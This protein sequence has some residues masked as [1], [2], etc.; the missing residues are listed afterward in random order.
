MWARIRVGANH[1]N[2]SSCEKMNEFHGTAVGK[3]APPQKLVKSDTPQRRP[4]LYQLKPPGPHGPK[5]PKIIKVVQ[6]SSGRVSGTMVSAVEGAR[7][8][9]TNKVIQRSSAELWGSAPEL[10]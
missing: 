10:P 2:L 7:P 4:S 5:F 1:P 8:K 3:I 6:K 9:D